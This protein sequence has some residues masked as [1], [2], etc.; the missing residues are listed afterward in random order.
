MGIQASERVQTE[1]RGDVE[2]HDH[3]QIV[4]SAVRAFGR[5]PKQ[6]ASHCFRVGSISRHIRIALSLLPAAEERRIEAPPDPFLKLH[7]HPGH[8]LLR[9]VN[10]WGAS[11]SGP[12]R[13]RTR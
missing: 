7:S 12:G 11:C 2:W 3:A 10:R 13:G 1:A 8:T 6:S 4:A 5:A 9:V